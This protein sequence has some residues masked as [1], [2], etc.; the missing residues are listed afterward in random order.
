MA[1]ARE[2]IEEA[3]AL[4]LVAFEKCDGSTN[5]SALAVE[6]LNSAA[7]KLHAAR[8]QLSIQIERDMAKTIQAIIGRA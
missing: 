2:L 1:N 4:A 7:G 3:R 8:V 5:E 6:L